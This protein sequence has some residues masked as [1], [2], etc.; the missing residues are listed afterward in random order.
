MDVG[1]AMAGW[2]QGRR[3]IHGR[4][5]GR[6]SGSGEDGA[7]RK[8]GRGMLVAAEGWKG[9]GGGHR[10]DRG[11]GAAAL[12][13]GSERKRKGGRGSGLRTGL[14]GERVSDLGKNGS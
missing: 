1:A 5:G 14:G 3:Q 2:M 13:P 4:R 12:G 8:E 11:G 7:G 10:R 9:G 6:R